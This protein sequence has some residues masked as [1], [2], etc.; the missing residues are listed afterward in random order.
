MDPLTRMDLVALLSLHFH[1]K[2]ATVSLSLSFQ[3]AKTKIPHTEGLTNNRNLFL[4]VWRMGSPQDLVSV[5]YY[6]LAVTSGGK[7]ARV[8]SLGPLL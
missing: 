1:T 4:T 3:G 6:L 7:K 5:T 2:S 8:I